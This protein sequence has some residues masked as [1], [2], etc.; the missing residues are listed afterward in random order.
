LLARDAFVA[1]GMQEGVGE[2]HER[3]EE[4]LTD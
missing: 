3:L 4:V 2:G 1:S